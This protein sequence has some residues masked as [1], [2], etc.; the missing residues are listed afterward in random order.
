MG[1]DVTFLI[2]DL[3]RM[4]N[5][6][7]G[8]R[9]VRQ[10]TVTGSIDRLMLRGALRMQDGLTMHQ[11][12]SVLVAIGKLCGK[13]TAEQARVRKEIA[14]AGQKIRCVHQNCIIAGVFWLGANSFLSEW[15]NSLLAKR[16]PSAF[17]RTRV[18]KF[19]ASNCSLSE[20]QGGFPKPV[21]QAIL[22]AA[23]RWLG[24]FGTMYI[25]STSL[26]DDSADV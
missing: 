5:C 3:Y 14:R 10:T 1:E 9:K 12:R 22:Q 4:C 18:K 24:G 26:A 23:M 2:D 8:L 16:S 11:Y 7:I 15:I 21:E 25:D 6:F 20:F 13:R 19:S 17:E